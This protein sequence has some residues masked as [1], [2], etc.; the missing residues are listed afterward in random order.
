MCVD[1]CIGWVFL[2]CINAIF[3]GRTQKPFHMQRHSPLYFLSGKFKGPQLNWHISSKECWPILWAFKRFDWLFQG[4]PNEIRDFC[5][6][7]NLV[8]IL[9]PSGKQAENKN[10]LSRLYRWGVILSEFSYTIQHVPGEFNVFAD[11]LTR[12]GVREAEVKRVHRG[13]IAFVGLTVKQQ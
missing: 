12:W 13:W 9:H 11:L 8:S 7:P 3:R 6:H 5:D 1:R 10:T 4:H 2:N